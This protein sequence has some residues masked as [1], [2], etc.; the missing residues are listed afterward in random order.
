V[1]KWACE[2]ELLIR[3]PKILGPFASRSA[4]DFVLQHT[5]NRS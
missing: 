2:A 1:M 5:H 3:P 4:I